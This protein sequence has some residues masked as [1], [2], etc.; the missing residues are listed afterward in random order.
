MLCPCCGAVLLILQ[1]SEDGEIISCPSCG[2]ELEIHL[3]S[4]ILTVSELQIEG[5]D[6]GE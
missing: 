2:T 1:D 5:E 3:N 4:G 6:W